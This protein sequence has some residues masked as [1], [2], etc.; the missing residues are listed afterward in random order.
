MDERWSG[1]A[2]QPV[3]Y[4]FSDI[5]QAAWQSVERFM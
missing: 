2:T 3:G 4:T 1:L 5:S